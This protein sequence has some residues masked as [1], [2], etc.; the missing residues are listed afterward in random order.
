MDNLGQYLLKT[1]GMYVTCPITVLKQ[2]NYVVN[3][4]QIRVHDI[5]NVNASLYAIGSIL[6]R[7][8]IGPQLLGAN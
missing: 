2:T 4:M 3:K 5:L 1:F 8:S 6:L 7:T